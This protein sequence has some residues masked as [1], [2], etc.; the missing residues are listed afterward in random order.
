VSGDDF[1]ALG[2]RKEAGHDRVCGTS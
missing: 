1:R 2:I